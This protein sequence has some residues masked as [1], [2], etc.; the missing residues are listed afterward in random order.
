MAE[1][2]FCPAPNE[3]RNGRNA[4]SRLSLLDRTVASEVEEC[5]LLGHV[6]NGKK[7]AVY[8]NT[9]EPFCFVTVGVQGAGKSHTTGCVLESCLVPFQAGHV[10]KLKEPMISLVLHYDQNTTSICESA[11]LLLPN[12]MINDKMATTFMKLL[13]IR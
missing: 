10:V 1:S 3:V 12:A 2:L 8:L 5:A 7:D 13:S 11:G 6:A 4:G 9:H